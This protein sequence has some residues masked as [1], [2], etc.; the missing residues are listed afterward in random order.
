M[1]GKKSRKRTLDGEVVSTKMQKTAVVLVKAKVLHPIYKKYYM[2]G[3]RYKVHDPESLCKK[4]DRVR[5][6]ECRPHSADKKWRLVSVL[7]TRELA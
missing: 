7:K 5:I 6:V 2:R 1:E 4:G 3:K